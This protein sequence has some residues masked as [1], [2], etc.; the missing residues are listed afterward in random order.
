MYI[1][2]KKKNMRNIKNN[3]QIF[4]NADSKASNARVFT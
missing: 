3:D 2:K 4:L 1:I